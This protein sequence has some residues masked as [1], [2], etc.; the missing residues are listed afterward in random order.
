MKYWCC[1][2]LNKKN[3]TPWNLLYKFQTLL[4]I[5]KH[6]SSFKSDIWRLNFDL[7]YDLSP[8]ILLHKCI[9]VCLSAVKILPHHTFSLFQIK[10]WP[11]FTSLV[12]AFTLTIF[13]IGL[14]MV[15]PLVL[16]VTRSVRKKQKIKMITI[17][18]KPEP[19]VSAD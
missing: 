11:N 6:W 16:L 2:H 12:I 14:V 15:V 9:F 7:N 5:V 1:F 4:H 10:V 19:T 18:L 3:A 8:F 17:K 13:V